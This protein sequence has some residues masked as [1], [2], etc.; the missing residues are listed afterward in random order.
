MLA[1]GQGGREAP[2]CPPQIPLQT[3]QTDWGPAPLC[4]GRALS[5]P[6]RRRPAPTL[7]VVSLL[8]SQNVFRSSVTLLAVTA[9][10]DEV[11]GWRQGCGLTAVGGGGHTARGDG[12]QGTRVPVPGHVPA[13]VEEP[14]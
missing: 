6:S 4:G 10:R 9:G 8:L 11:E 7:S 5:C 13:H 14:G 1:W 2:P 3:P 12:S